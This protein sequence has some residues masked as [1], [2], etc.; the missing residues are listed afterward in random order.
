MKNVMK[1]IGLISLYALITAFLFLTDFFGSQGELIP[2]LVS[3]LASSLAIYFGVESII[4][5]GIKSGPGKIAFNFT[6]GIFFWMLGDIL[7]AYVSELS[8]IADITYIAGYLFFF[9]AII[10]GLT[11]I[12]PSL[13]RNKKR[14]A[15]FLSMV[16]LILFSYYNLRPVTINPDITL[17]ENII[18]ITY[19]I[20]DLLL[21]LSVV[22]IFIFLISGV[23]S[24]GW[25]AM[26]IGIFLTFI[27]DFVYY[28]L[29]N[30]EFL[31]SHAFLNLAWI[32]SYLFFALGFVLAKYNAEST[33]KN[34]FQTIEKKNI[35]IKKRRR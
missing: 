8:S 20:S 30:E 32:Y 3:W 1:K 35:R 31:S 6:S 28:V 9:A 33:I 21:I 4:Y 7:W 26:G 23:Y 13:A 14:V 27:G 18:G 17:L 15:L 11:G 22:A 29:F 25:L 19:I 2:N 24:I 5:F 12:K 10:L 16:F 34:A